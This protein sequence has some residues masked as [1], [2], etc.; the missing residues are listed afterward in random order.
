MCVTPRGRYCDPGSSTDPPSVQGGPRTD[1]ASN[2]QQRS[3]TKT[4]IIALIRIAEETKTNHIY[5]IISKIHNLTV[6]G[7]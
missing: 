4:C 2:L 7:R 3:I 5:N 1:E 6:L